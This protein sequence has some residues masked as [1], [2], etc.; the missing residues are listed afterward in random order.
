LL[1]TSIKKKKESQIMYH[2]NVKNRNK[3]KGKLFILSFALIVAAWTVFG[4]VEQGQAADVNVSS[5]EGTP[6]AGGMIQSIT[7]DKDSKIKDGLRV[8]SAM[9]KKNIVPT[10]KIDGVMGFTRLYNV[11]FEEAMDAV[12][13]TNF[14]YEQEGQLIKVYTEEEY[15]KI[16][17][18]KAR[19]VHKVF[20]LYYISAAE[21]SKLIKP[22]LSSSGKIE[23]TSAA[24]IG[25]PTDETISAQIGGGDTVAMNDTIVICDFPENVTKAEDV[26]KS[27]D[28]KPKQILVEATILSATL[29]EDMQFGIDWQ[30]LKGTAI[31]ALS[32]ITYG[33]PEYLKVAGTGASIESALTGGLTFGVTHDDVA[34]FIR[35]VEEITDVTVLANPKI[36]TVNK[37]LGQVYIGTKLGYRE[38]DTFDAQGNRV[39]GA[40]KFLDTGTKLSFRPFICDDGYIRMDIHPKD[41]SGTVPG[42][43]PQEISAELVT[44]IM[45]KDGQTIVIGG[46][47]RDSVQ[48]DKSQVPLLGDLPFVGGAFRGTANQDKRQEVIVLLT[49]HIIEDPRETGGQARADDVSRKRLGA[50]DELDWLNSSRMVE[51]SY[52]KAVKYYLAGNKEAALNKLNWALLVRPTHIEALRLKERIIRETTPD[53]KAAIERIMR[54]VIE[55]EESGNWL[56]R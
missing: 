3:S 46:L 11:T 21:A 55:R 17:E 30:T 45:V 9:Y 22:V 4:D 26:L 27:V 14:K 19:M 48:T 6:A 34:A 38:G 12:L 7:F 40:V 50:T 37:Q 54:N 13:G 24:K 18:D 29:T 43:I 5:S 41:S 31:T 42:G 53:D 20:T 36:L 16:K 51:D 23:V 1:K 35:A 28:V 56:R 8:L 44:N 33:A 39:E 15:K 49:P 2:N 32:G 52:A 10:S 25:V 47:F